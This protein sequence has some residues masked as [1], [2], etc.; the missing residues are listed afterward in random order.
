MKTVLFVLSQSPGA[1][2]LNYQYAR[3][4]LAISADARPVVVLAARAVM[5][6]AA[7]YRDT[8]KHIKYADQER[9][10]VEMEVPFYAVEE[11]LA[12]HGVTGAIKPHVQAIGPDA[13]AQLVHGADVVFN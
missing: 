5:L 2:D 7:D 10:L 4:A 11:D 6:A 8:N 13:L 1:S 9:Y 12:L 3:M